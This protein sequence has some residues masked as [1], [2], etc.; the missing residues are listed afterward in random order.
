M[1]N[2]GSN[3]PKLIT[4]GYTAALTRNTLL[5]TAFLPKTLGNES[6][7]VDAGFALGA[8]LLSHPFEVARVLIVCK[9]Q[10]RMIGSTLSTLKSV[11]SAEGVA[12]L[13]KGFVPRTIHLFPLL[14]SLVAASYGGKNQEAFE[15]VRSNPILGSLKLSTSP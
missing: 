9:E 8:I 7:A 12:G 14:F 3:L 4:L 11:Y 1:K 13:Y 5:M 2:W 15:G 10:N 6:L